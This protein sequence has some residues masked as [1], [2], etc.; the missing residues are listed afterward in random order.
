M[1]SGL[2]W[3]I[4]ELIMHLEMKKWLTILSSD[5]YLS[6]IECRIMTTLC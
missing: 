1:S 5:F 4:W 6:V 2:D 3:K